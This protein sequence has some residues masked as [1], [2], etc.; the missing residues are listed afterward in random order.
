M[1]LLVILNKKLKIVN[2]GGAIVIYDDDDVDLMRMIIQRR[3]LEPYQISRIYAITDFSQNNSA[4]VKIFLVILKVLFYL[5][6]S[7]F[8]HI[9]LHGSNETNMYID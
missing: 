9:D 5:G 4:R 8:D 7:I 3:I 2:E 6:N 1:V